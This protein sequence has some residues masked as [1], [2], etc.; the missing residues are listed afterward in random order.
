MNLQYKFPAGDWM[1]EALPVGNGRLGAMLFGGVPVERIQF[2]ES[3]LWIGDEKS[4]GAY[5][6]FGDLFVELDHQ[7]VSDYRRELDLRRAVNTVCYI[8]DD[9]SFRRECFASHPANIIVMRF[10]AEKPGMYSGTIRLADMHNGTIAAEGDRLTAS[11]SLAGYC[12]FKDT[13]YDIALDYEAQVRVLH[14]GGSAEAADGHIIIKNVNSLTL[15][16]N[17]GTDFVQ[18][19]LRNWRGEH[20]HQRI[21][22]QL[23][24]AAATPFEKL[25][26]EHIADYQSLF[27]RVELDL[28]GTACDLPSDQRLLKY[29]EGPRDPSFETLIFQYGRYLMISSS[30]DALPAN[31]QGIWNE[32]NTPPWR[33]DFHTDLNVQMNY[34]MSG[35]ANLSECF[36]PFAAWLN[37]IREVRIAETKEAFGV[38]GWTMHAENGPFGGST[39][40]WI[41]STSAWCMQNL[42][43]HYEFT[44][45]R[46]Y[47]RTTAWPMMKEVCEF[48]LDRLKEL[49]DGTLV[50]P[51]GFSPEQHHVPREDGVSH[52]QQ[53]VWDLFNNTV[54]AADVLAIDRPFRDLIAAKRD[55]LLGPKIGSWGQLQEWAVDRDD[56]ND[57]HRHLSHLVAVYPCRQITPLADPE[58]AE[59]AR[60]SLN[61]RGDDGISWSSAWK[62]VLWARLHNGD[63]AYKLLG[64]LLRRAIETEINYDTGGGLYFNLLPAMPPFQIEAGL[65]YTAAVCEMLLQSHAGE[66]HLLPALPKAWASGRV[67]GLR[68]RGGCTVDMEWKDGDVVGYQ[69]T[70]DEPHEVK[71]RVNGRVETYTSKKQPGKKRK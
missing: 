27:N 29:T 59:A 67:K 1:Q 54:E 32:S 42:W 55:K 21:I 70:S 61:S 7:E 62:A 37:S 56:P 5:Q 28:G 44:G 11:G 33:G 3:T 57:H 50:A 25:L 31:L 16:L 6:A 49:P 9:V 69:I 64:S 30:R 47:L 52:D 36:L 48:W 43:D 10:T 65:C 58:L 15:L 19:R 8:K 2:N 26:A 41:E 51:D 38:R 4:T 23:D 68:A 46:D 34:W 13:S 35:P 60:V 66:I 12:Y 63:R 22:A 18:D 20:P 24:A 45:D 71:V 14:E 40:Q 17:A 39:W 53:L